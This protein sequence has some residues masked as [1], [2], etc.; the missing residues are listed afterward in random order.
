M[1]YNVTTKPLK[2]MTSGTKC[3]MDVDLVVS[4]YEYIDSLDTIVLFSGDSDYLSAITKF[5]SLGKQVIIYSFAEYLAWELKA[6]AIKNPR[7][8][9]VELDPLRSEL[10]LPKSP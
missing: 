5:H 1:G 4:V 2:Y 6:F 3:D 8:R 7:C 10:E 9:Y